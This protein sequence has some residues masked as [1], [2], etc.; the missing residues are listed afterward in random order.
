MVTCGIVIELDHPLSSRPFGMNPLALTR[1]GSRGAVV[2]LIA[3]T[4]ACGQTGPNTSSSTH[5]LACDTDLDCA[6][7]A[8]DAH[9]GGD[10]FCA[11][12]EGEHLA[13][14]LVYSDEF[15]G[16]TLDAAHWGY[17]E[18]AG[19]RNDEAQAYT[20]RPENV[21]VEDGNLIL[22][23]RAEEYDGAAF[24]SGSVNSEGLFSATFGRIEARISAPVGRGC[25]SAFWMLPENPA[26]NVRSCIDGSGCYDGTWPAWGDMAVANLQSQLPGQVLGTVS[27]GI[28]DDALEGVTHG[29]FGGADATVDEPSAFHDYALEWG[30]ARLEWFVDGVLVRTLELPPPD[31]YS[32]DGD[33]PFRQPFHLRLNLALGGLDQTP[34]A[35][36]Y[37]QEMRVDW[38]R[39]WQ[40]RGD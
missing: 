10:G 12:P 6:N 39:V 13:Q 17:E 7:L 28:W 24:T 30:P 20:G 29:V 15:D 25:S 22:T 40:W 19:I 32:P 37:P 14:E 1:T 2:S 33:D 27:Y 35:A 31:L 4:V 5:W 3:V 23:A 9:C 18:G 36:D 8:V 26:S 38:L 21:K 16:E 34:D 11:T